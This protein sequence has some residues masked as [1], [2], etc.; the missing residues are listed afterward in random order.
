MISRRMTLRFRGNVGM[1]NRRMTLRFRGNVQAS[2]ARIIGHVGDRSF[3]PAK[4]RVAAV[5][6]ASISAAECAADKKPAS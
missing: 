4:T 1:T 3:K 6:V 2:A 5:M